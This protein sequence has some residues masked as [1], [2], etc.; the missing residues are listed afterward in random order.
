MVGIDWKHVLPA[1]FRVLEGT[2]DPAKYARRFE[3]FFDR[4]CNYEPA[5]LFVEARQVATPPQLKELA[6]R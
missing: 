1:W 5:E 3:T 6:K 4:H 2:A